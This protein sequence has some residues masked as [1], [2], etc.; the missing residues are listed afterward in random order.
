M[1][2]VALMV[3]RFGAAGATLGDAKRTAFAS[4]PVPQS[5]TAY[6]RLKETAI[7]MNAPPSR[8]AAWNFVKEM[9]YKDGFLEG[10]PGENGI[11]LRFR[12]AETMSKQGHS[13]MAPK[14]EFYSIFPLKNRRNVSP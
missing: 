7:I 4:G 1:R 9:E 11:V 13:K 3:F 8:R 14:R 12:W 5:A 6:P 2:T 10:R